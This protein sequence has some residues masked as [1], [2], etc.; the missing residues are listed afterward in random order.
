MGSD[1]DSWR[2]GLRAHVVR[3]SGEKRPRRRTREV[4]KLAG[5]EE[6]AR[7][8]EGYGE[9]QPCELTIGLRYRNPTT[10]DKPMGMRELAELIRST[11]GFYWWDVDEYDD[12]VLRANAY[13]GNDL[14]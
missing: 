1:Y 9:G 2:E 10:C 11:G 5:A 13:T 14:F 4:C 6:A 7:A 3:S 12:G 8:V